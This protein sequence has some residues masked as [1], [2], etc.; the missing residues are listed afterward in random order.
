[1]SIPLDRRE[2]LKLGL[3]SASAQ[4]ASQRWSFAAKSLS[5]AAYAKRIVIIGAGLAGLVAAYELTQAG[6]D[7]D[8]SQV[9]LEL[10]AGERRLGMSGL[11][12]KYLGN[13][14]RGIGDPSAP[15]W[16]SAQARA[17][18]N[19]TMAEFLR[20]Q[21]ASHAAIELL[22]YPFTSAEDDPVSFL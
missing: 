8:L 7:L 4:F 16:P 10:K 20:Q 12:Q 19:V 9:P 18:D 22:E 6:S 21:G 3:L 13:A 5:P 17:Y 11:V 2:F 14:L 1:M 15:D